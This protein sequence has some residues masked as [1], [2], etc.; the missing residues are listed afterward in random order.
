MRKL[1][2]SLVAVVLIASAALFFWARAVFTQD[3]VRSALAAQL[4]EALGQPVSVGTIS[5]SIYPR[6]T[7]TLGNVTI[8]QPAG[9]QISSLD[10]GTDFRALLSRRIEHG[11]AR[12]EGARIQLPLMPLGS[13]S[14]GAPPPAGAA[15]GL[16]VQ[17]VSID[18]IVLSDVELVSAGRTL[19]GDVEIVP[20]DG[21]YT[22]RR[23]A[24]SAE[25][26]SI[27]ATGRITDL[28]GPI[29]ELTVKA[30]DLNLDRLL[31]FL[32][33]FASSGMGAPATGASGGAASRTSAA[34]LKVDIT[35]SRATLAGIALENVSTRVNVTDRDL[36]LEPL[37][38]ATFGGTYEG[39]LA[40]RAGETEALW[41][42]LKGAVANIDVPAV[43]RF[44]GSSS[45]PITGRLTGQLDV[46]GTGA[47]ASAAMRATRGSA[48]LSI[49]DG[50]VRNLGLV[51][52]VVVAGSMRGDAATIAGATAAGSKEASSSPD[53]PFKVIRATLAIASLQATT[54]DLAFEGTD[55]S[56]AARGSISLT[57]SDVNLAGRVQLS[58]ALTA[59]AGTDL[60]R[61]TQQD[62]RVTLPVTVTGPAD[63]LSVGV[64]VGAL[65]KR[66][67][68]NRA[69]EEIRRTIEKGLGGLF[70]KPPR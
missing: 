68:Q 12:L 32:G 44:A 43:L 42:A 66:A 67:I 65:M 70:K 51:R 23:L 11:A 30:G 9:I 47:D 52:A 8:G 60:V 36:R 40:V 64:D 59:R 4:S 19:R 18:Q 48:R 41:F 56:V 53:E 16:P 6:V 57:G 25:D 1:L 54:N 38:F 35:A 7:V 10:V 24:L 31:T 49:Q 27:E 15:A 5:A 20:E 28:S 26:A 3:T 45:E 13:A 63:A 34:N 69:E 29:G 21:G 58:D 39:S 50:I 55:V 33:D 46:S 61:V 2:I 62:G 14:G 17:L 22:L 37:T